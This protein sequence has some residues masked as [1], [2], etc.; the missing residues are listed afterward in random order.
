MAYDKSV[1]HRSLA[2]QYQENAKQFV[3]YCV[4]FNYVISS[5]SCT[6]ACHMAAVHSLQSACYAPNFT[7]PS[8]SPL[9]NP[10]IRD[11]MMRS[12]VKAPYHRF[13]VFV[14]RARVHKAV[15]INDLS[16]LSTLYKVHFRHHVPTPGCMEVIVSS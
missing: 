10:C 3:L 2:Q 14:S 6:R 5:F 1:M 16:E 8:I 11:T 4:R 12:A 7:Q 15:T 13:A 9:T